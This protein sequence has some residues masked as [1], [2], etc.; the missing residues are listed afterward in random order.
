MAY[1]R[2]LFVGKLARW[3]DYMEHYRLPAWDELPDMDLYMDQVVALVGRYLDLIPHDEKN[4]VVTPSIIN[5][6]VRLKVMPAPQ[7]KRYSRR[8]LAYALMICSMKVSLTLTEIQKILPPDLEDE[9]I[10]QL[11]NDFVLKMTETARVFIAQVNAVAEQALVPGNE[12]G[13]ASLVLHSVVSSV[14]YKLLTVKL[15]ALESHS[16]P[17]QTKEA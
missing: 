1:D 16:E 10:S 6:Y 5:N 3:Q 2:D 11:Y 17:E 14:L 13:C 9:Q 8:H 12:N 15:T 7:R 4:P